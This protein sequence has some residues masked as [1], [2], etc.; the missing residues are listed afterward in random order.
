MIFYDNIYANKKRDELFMFGI[1]GTKKKNM[2]KY[3]SDINRTIFQNRT[4]TKKKK[5]YPQSHKFT[6]KISV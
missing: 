5:N 1:K 3:I 2:Y 6:N 4:P